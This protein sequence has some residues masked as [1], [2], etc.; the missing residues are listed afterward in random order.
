[1][2]NASGRGLQPKGLRVKEA[3]DFKV[4]TKGA[5]S[6]ELKVLVKGPSECIFCSPKGLPTILVYERLCEF[7]NGANAWCDV[8]Y[9]RR[10][11]RASEGAGSWRWGVRVRIL[12]SCTWKIHC[13]HHLGRTG[14]STQVRYRKSNVNVRL[15][16]IGISTTVYYKHEYFTLAYP[17]EYYVSKV[18]GCGT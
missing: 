10:R 13:G 9:F 7:K 14:Y 11:R 16:S 2:C 3:A 17:H 12:P 8:C 18:S 6:G 4:F 5:G 15:Y 1:M